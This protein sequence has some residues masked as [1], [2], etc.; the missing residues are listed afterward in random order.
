MNIHFFQNMPFEK[1]E[2]CVRCGSK[3]LITIQVEQTD[4]DTVSGYGVA[5]R[6]K[7]EEGVA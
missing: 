4:T 3:M 2:C 5:Y 1:E 6:M 7:T